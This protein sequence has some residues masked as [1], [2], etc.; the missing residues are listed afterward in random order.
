VETPLLIL[1]P[2]KGEH[3]LPKISSFFFAS[4]KEISGSK[5]TLVRKKH[6]V[7]SSPARSLFVLLLCHSCV[8]TAP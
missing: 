3:F 8:F 2:K 4:P 5:C 6:A 7:V 1:K